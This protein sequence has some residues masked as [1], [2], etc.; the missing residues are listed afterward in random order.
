MI[1]LLKIQC[2]LDF[3]FDNLLS[4]SCFLGIDK[5]K[6]ILYNMLV[7]KKTRRNSIMKDKRIIAMFITSIF[8]FV[9]SVSISLGVA[10]AFADPV[11]AAG[12]PELKFSVSDKTEKSIVFDPVAEFNDNIDDFIIRKSYDEVYF[13]NEAIVDDV[14]LAKLSITNDTDSIARIRVHAQVAGSTT[15]DYARI[16][17]FD[18]VGEKTYKFKA[19]LFSAEI[20]IPAG[21]TGKFILAGYVKTTYATE[22]VDFSL[23]MDMTV[24]I[25]QVNV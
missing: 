8:A 4:K 21:E 2:L 17:I 19:G 3:L 22:E 7:R 6:Y 10:F 12:L 24:S 25:D 20:E 5:N 14:R 9:A 16:A 18:V 11:I 15:A 13:A 1:V 23:P